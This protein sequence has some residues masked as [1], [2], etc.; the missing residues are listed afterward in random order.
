MELNWLRKEADGVVL[1]I[2]AT[3][4]ARENGVAGV[5]GEWLRI[6]LQAP[7][8]DGKANEALLRWLA[9]VLDVPKTAVELV[10]GSSARIKR[11]RI[12]GVNATQVRARL[13]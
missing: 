5:E 11:V 8:V 12:R 3:P 13:A 2:K 10:A 4:R 7:P 6:R 1:T 9:G